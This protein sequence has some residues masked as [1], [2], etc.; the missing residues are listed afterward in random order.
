MGT[1]AEGGLKRSYLESHSQVVGK[2][3][4]RCATSSG[5]GIISKMDL[6]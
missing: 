5:V 6:I 4:S 1:Q 2:M 3:D